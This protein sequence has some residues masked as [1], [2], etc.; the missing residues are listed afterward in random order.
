M[1]ASLVLYVVSVTDLMFEQNLMNLKR[2]LK[3]STGVLVLQGSLGESV[4]TV[5]SALFPAMTVEEDALRKIFDRCGLI[6]EEWRVCVKESR[7]YF[8]LLKQ[9]QSGKSQ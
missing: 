6:V 1:V 2:S 3:P 7:H 4:Y 5:G 8:A 9:V